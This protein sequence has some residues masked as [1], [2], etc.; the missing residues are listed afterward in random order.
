[1][2]TNE[3]D[4]KFTPLTVSERTIDRVGGA[5]I[6]AKLMNEVFI[7]ATTNKVCV[8]FSQHAGFFDPHFA[9]AIHQNFGNGRVRQYRGERSKAKNF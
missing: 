3:V 5:G 6:Y 4:S 7:A 2:R 1:R 8:I 9:L